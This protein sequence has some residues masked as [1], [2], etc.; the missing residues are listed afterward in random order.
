[1]LTITEAASASVALPN[2]STTKHVTSDPRGLSRHQVLDGEL[3]SG[4]FAINL[5]D[6]L[7]SRVPFLPIAAS[8]RAHRIMNNRWHAICIIFQTSPKK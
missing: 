6:E 2:E 4:R 5:V 8:E 1:M 7:P 3:E